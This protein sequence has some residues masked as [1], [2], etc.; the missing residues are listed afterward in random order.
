MT[1]RDHDSADQFIDSQIKL[2]KRACE[3]LTLLKTN[4]LERSIPGNDYML[5]E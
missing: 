2:E 1:C 4:D 3:G 5:H